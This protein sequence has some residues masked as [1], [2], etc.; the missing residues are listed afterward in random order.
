LSFSSRS[1]AESGISFTYPLSHTRHLFATINAKLPG[2]L[3][4]PGSKDCSTE[5]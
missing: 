3:E 1:F 5:R 4:V 2:T